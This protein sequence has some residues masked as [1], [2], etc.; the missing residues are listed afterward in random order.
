[1]ALGSGSEFNY[2]IRSQEEKLILGITEDPII[3]L[4]DEIL[5]TAIARQ[6]SDIHLQPQE[7]SFLIRYRID[8]ILYDQYELAKEQAPLII[9]RLKILAHLDIAERRVPQD[10]R[11][12]AIAQSEND[13]TASNIID[14][15]IATFPTLYGEKMVVRILDRSLR[16]LTLQALG[17]S[18]SLFVQ[19]NKIMQ[20]PHGLFLV[21]GPTGCGKTTMLYALIAAMNT[22]K[23]NIVT[24]EDPVEYELAGITQSAVNPKAGF[25]F[26]NGLRAI[27]RQDPDI[28]MVGEIRDRTTAQIAIEAALTGHLVLSTLHTNDAPSAVARLIEMGIEPFLL[29][30]TLVGVLAQRLIRVLCQSCKKILK[31]TDI[32]GDAFFNLLTSTDTLY[33]SS[34]CRSCFNVGYRGRIG[35]FELLGISDDFRI[36]VMKKADVAVLRSVARSTGMKPLLEDALQKVRSGITSIDEVMLIKMEANNQ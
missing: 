21:T 6:A 12:R 5:F 18:D 27:L 7:H 20:Q 24:I 32:Q 16:L 8:G 35:V 13:T 26:E 17:L 30:A 22:H 28:I 15:R 4:V 36:H 9:S 3:Q 1:M 10:G 23:K 14:F 11:L 19:L 33:S 29:S 31:T 2:C 34:G 25:T